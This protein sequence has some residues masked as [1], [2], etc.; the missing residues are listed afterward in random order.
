MKRTEASESNIRIVGLEELDPE[1]EIISYTGFDTIYT[2]I[3]RTL[4]QWLQKNFRNCRFSVKRKGVL[5][6][7]SHDK[8]QIDDEICEISN[9][10]LFLK[11]L[12]L[13]T[14]A[15]KKELESRGFFTFKVKTRP[16]TGYPRNTAAKMATEKASQLVKQVEENTVL[17]EKASE[18]VEHFFDQ[19]RKGTIRENDIRGFVDEFVDS[20]S[21]EALRVIASLKRSDHTYAH[22]VDACAI[23]S[24][25]YTKINQKKATNGIFKDNR[26]IA[27]AGFVHDFGKARIPKDVLDSTARFEIDSPEMR[28]LRS[29]PQYG[30]ELL[31]N[32]NAADY[33]L[34]MTLYH[35][36]KEDSSMN[37]SY[38]KKI[39]GIE[40]LWETRLLSI[41]DVY[42][43]L[44]GRRPYKK[45]WSPPAAV[46]YLDALA[47]IE[48]D[49]EVWN[50]FLKTIGFYPV[51]SLVELN[52]GSIAFVMDVREDHPRKPQVV[53][54]QDGN[55][56]LQKTHMILDLFEEPEFEIVKDI[57]AQ[58]YFGE[59]ALE[60]FTSMRIT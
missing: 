43:A 48:F 44:T 5:Q 13:P 19:A 4:C 45:S 60:Q 16:K 14:E 10:P 20:A 52:D 22:C 32:M 8:L 2:S 47:G 33:I 38:P 21:T 42:Q 57:D 41:V 25:V 28:L 6:E 46:R 35:H 54:V 23:F 56:Q 55:N 51:G 49:P 26:E 15:L 29:H 34:N 58:D 17:R 36:I 7:C 50:E 31:L 40:V 12:T 30:V 27:Y 39:E 18:A 9:F 53:V 1:M 59:K 3:D 11:K 24:S 37:S